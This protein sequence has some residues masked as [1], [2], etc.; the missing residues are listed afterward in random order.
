MSKSLTEKST[1]RRSQRLIAA[2]VLIAFSSVLAG[3]SSSFGSNFDPTRSARLPRHQE[4]AA[5]RAQ[6]GL[7]RRRARPRA[8]RAEGIV[9]GRASSSDPN[10]QSPRRAAAAAPGSSN[11]RFSNRPRP[12]TRSQP[13][14]G[15]PQA[16]KRAKA[17]RQI[18]GNRRGAR[19]CRAGWRDRRRLA[20][21][22][23]RRPPRLRR[24]KKIV[25]KRTT[26]PPPDP[27]GQ[28]QAA[29]P[30]S[31]ATGPGIAAGLPGADAERQFSR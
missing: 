20:G 18:A 1:M 28:P 21:G 11:P 3:C 16:I 14:P 23:T 6:A 27:N 13:P 15:S 29:A 30:Q 7:P 12:G 9:Q 8:G 19:C 2:A 10:A 26:A 25:R 31:S 22:R 24:S 5:R 17:K 4:E